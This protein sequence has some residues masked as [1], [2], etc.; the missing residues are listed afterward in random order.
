[1]FLSIKKS[2]HFI[3]FKKLFLYLIIIGNTKVIS[4]FNSIF[5]SIIDNYAKQIGYD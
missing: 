5:A 2:I 3:L 1:M 4:I